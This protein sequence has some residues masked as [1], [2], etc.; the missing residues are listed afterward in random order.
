M[1]LISHNIAIV[2]YDDANSNS[3]PQL[4]FFD[5]R[6]SVQNTL[7][8]NPLETRYTIPPNTSQVLFSG[9]RITAID[10]TTT[11]QLA[12]NAVNNGL[13]RVTATSGTAPSFRTDRGLN[14]TG[15]TVSISV[16]NNSTAN[17]T[18][19]T[20]NFANVQVGDNVF[21]PSTLTGDSSL[22]SPFNVGNG[23]YWTVISKASGLTPK[24]IT[25]IRLAGASFSGVTETV[26]PTSAGQFVAFSSSGVQSGDTLEISSGF[27][28][29]TQSTFKIV[30]V[31][32]TWVEFASTLNLPLE[33]GIQPG[34]TG[35]V[36]Y[37]SNKKYL[38]VEANYEV[39]IRLN[40]DVGTT[41]QNNRIVPRVVG[42]KDGIG[43]FETWGTVW[44]LEIQNRSKTSSVTITVHSA[45]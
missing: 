27:S 3:N 43:W 38:R 12:L 20:N 19:T 30:N 17:V 22:N 40:T 11:F 41:N 21:I 36:F 23:G 34:A 42:T 1:P 18:V 6:R 15:D 39:A 26:T 45:E 16:N 37:V 24:T 8:D 29:V 44:A 5:W 9:N 4:R 32:P 7:V 31:T 35:M 10:S 13:Y 25:I 2:A 14:L 28:P 33:S